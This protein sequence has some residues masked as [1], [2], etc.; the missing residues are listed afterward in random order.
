M[1]WI[2]LRQYREELGKLADEE[3]HQTLAFIHETSFQEYLEERLKNPTEVLL[4]FKV[5][6]AFA[7]HWLHYIHAQNGVAAE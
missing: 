5:W 2:S 1:N 6:D 4:S 3:R 7:E